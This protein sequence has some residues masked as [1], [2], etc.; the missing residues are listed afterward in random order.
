[1]AG[2]VSRHLQVSQRKPPSGRIWSQIKLHERFGTVAIHKSS[3]DKETVVEA[4]TAMTKTSMV[5]SHIVLKSP[6]GRGM[7]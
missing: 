2:L 6:V 3:Y 4:Q 7:K 5:Q 1:M